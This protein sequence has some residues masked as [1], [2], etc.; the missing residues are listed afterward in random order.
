[1]RLFKYIYKYVFLVILKTKWRKEQIIAQTYA[2]WQTI[3]AL[4]TFKA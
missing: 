3:G 4:T 1:M 2:M